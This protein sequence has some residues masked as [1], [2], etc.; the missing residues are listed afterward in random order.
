MK[1]NGFTVVELLIT[2]SLTTVIV[3]LLT[4]IIIV[5]RNLYIENGIKTKLLTKQAILAKNINDDLLNLDITKIERCTG[6]DIC[7]NFTYKESG[8]EKT[9][10]LIVD[11]KGKFI[12]YDGIATNLLSGSTFGN[13]AVYYEKILDTNG[14]KSKKNSIFNV[15]VPI[16]HT[17]FEQENFGFN[18]VYQYNSKAVTVS[19][20][21]L[22]DIV[23]SEKRIYLIGGD[24]YKYVDV[25]YVDPGYYVVD[26]K[27][28]DII[29]SEVDLKSDNPLVNVTGY[30]GNTAG[31][32]YTLTYTIYNIN[33]E[34]MS[35]VSRTV[36]VIE[37]VYN[38]SFSGK[39]EQ[40]N[41]PVSGTYEIEVWGASGGG[42]SMMRGKGGYA[43]DF[44]ALSTSDKLY[45]TVGGQ[46]VTGT[47]NSAAIGGYN[48]GGNSGKSSTYLASSGGGASDVR[49]GSSAVNSRIIVAGGGGGGGSRN[50]SS[51]TCNGGAGGGASGTTGT[52]S[53]DS[54][55]GGAG[56]S[57]SGGA[58]ATYTTTSSGTITSLPTAGALLQGG[59]GASYTTSDGV[60]YAAGGGGGGYYGGGGGSRYGGG[61]GGSGYCANASCELFDGTKTFISP[62]HT[63]YE[64]GHDGN[65]YVKISLRSVK[66]G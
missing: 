54:Y 17:L 3:L 32:E 12:E 62:D 9:K 24:D 41:V 45:V 38:Y 30:V 52:C 66:F 4:E 63:T 48:G 60:T 18:V 11:R 35:Q 59:N 65:G 27:S 5:V 55:L 10:K 26:S 37:S 2:V 36:K 42:S 1:K 49:L 8:S 34:I 31:E 57:S 23:D 7:V 39:V 61:G 14:E 19:N 53:S 56:T 64:I 20:V 47:V 43:K 22:T 16:Y 28:G 21:N 29:T 44:M 46:G 40:F 13:V 58:A 25:N 6:Y 51:F 50:D 15:E 33:N